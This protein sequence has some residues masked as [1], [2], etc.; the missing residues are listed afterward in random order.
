[1]TYTLLL[2]D[3]NRTIQRVVDLTF[4]DGDVTVEATGFKKF[5][6]DRQEL[7]V[8]QTA[9]IDIALEVGAASETSQNRS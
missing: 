3:E 9:T 2:A 6:R 1:M 7:Q 8:S 4:A 5:L